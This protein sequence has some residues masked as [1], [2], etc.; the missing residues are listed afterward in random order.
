MLGLT[1]SSSD[2]ESDSDS[3]SDV[4]EEKTSAAN[5]RAEKDSNNETELLSSKEGLDSLGKGKRKLADTPSTSKLILP[6]FN[7]M[8]AR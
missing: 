5:Q 4:P 3:N 8:I 7:D 6:G 1:Y 2:S